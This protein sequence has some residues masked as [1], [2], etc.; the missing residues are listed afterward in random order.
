M[1]K[2]LSLILAAL[3][4]LTLAACG[5]TTSSATPAGS[6]EAASTPADSGTPTLNTVTPGKLTMATD[7]GFAPYEYVEGEKVVGIDADI[8]Q[9]IADYYGLELVIQDMDFTNALL[10]PQNGT[11]D[12]AAAGVSITDER[13]ETMDFTMEY[14]ESDQVILVRK[15]FADIKGEEDLANVKIGVQQGTT[16]DLYC[17]DMGY[18]SVNAYKKNLVAAE[19]LK[20]GQIDCMILDN[21][22]A[23]AILKQNT[24]ELE[25]LDM[26]LFTDVYAMAVKKGNTEMAEALNVVLQQLIDEGKIEQF[27]QKHMDAS[28]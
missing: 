7:A 4:L 5:G 3:M 27:T 26:V 15:G 1:K 10:A 18:E 17:Q 25:I 21:M 8:A 19:D 20:N 24:E 2:V 23:E 22:P 6:S 16:A 11:A 28:M 9:A 13:L 14:A 12:F